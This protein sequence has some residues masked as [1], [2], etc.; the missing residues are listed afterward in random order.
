LG[1][2]VEH[3][4]A[5]FGRSEKHLQASCGHIYEALISHTLVKS[6]NGTLRPISGKCLNTI[7][8]I[9]MGKCPINAYRPVMG[10]CLKKFR[11]W[12]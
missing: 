8:R 11:R 7:R 4:Q 12:V 3:L 5:S 1:K 2:F 10:K 9:I 6:L